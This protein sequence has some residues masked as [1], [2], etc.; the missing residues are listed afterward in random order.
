MPMLQFRYAKVDTDLEFLKSLFMELSE[1]LKTEVA[2]LQIVS[3]YL[4]LPTELE[5]I[6]E[7]TDAQLTFIGAAP[8]VLL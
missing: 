6:L 3:G 2:Y 4:N 5:D 7:K 8:E 1:S